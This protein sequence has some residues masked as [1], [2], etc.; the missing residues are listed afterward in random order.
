MKNDVQQFMNALAA[1]AVWALAHPSKS[2]FEYIN[3]TKIKANERMKDAFLTW[4]YVEHPKIKDAQREAFE[5]SIKDRLYPAA[6]MEHTPD[7]HH[8]VG[9]SWGSEWY[10]ADFYLCLTRAIIQH[11]QRVGNDLTRFDAPAHIAANVF[12]LNRVEPTPEIIQAM[13]EHLQTAADEGT[14][15]YSEIDD[16]KH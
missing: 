10:I 1:M 4:F 12:D 13:H 16:R 2:R 8:P 7:G 9:W 5:Q 3:P 15:P 11:A 14:R 6:V